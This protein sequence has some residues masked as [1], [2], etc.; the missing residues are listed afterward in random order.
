VEKVNEEVASF[1]GDTPGM[2]MD[3]Y[4]LSHGLDPQDMRDLAGFITA[5][6][7]HMSN[8][9]ELMDVDTEDKQELLEKAMEASVLMAYLL[10]RHEGREGVS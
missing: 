7:F 1:G 5:I 9:I 10:G 6:G 4:L 2:A 3:A 8:K